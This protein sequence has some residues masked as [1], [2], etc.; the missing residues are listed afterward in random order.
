MLNAPTGDRMSPTQ[1]YDAAINEYLGPDR[2]SLN[3]LAHKY[4]IPETS[5]RRGIK[6]LGI[7]RGG[8]TERK[9]RL[10]ENHFSG[11]LANLDS[12]GRSPTDTENPELLQARIELEAARDIEDMDGALT[13]CRR[14]LWRLKEIVDTLDCP[15]DIKAACEATARAV[16]VIRRIRGLDAPVDFSDWSDDELTYLAQTGRPPSGRR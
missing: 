10:V 8:A 1:D 12:P 2:P 14:A 5:L 11:E 4:G 9:R 13:V 7:V 16:D 3:S 15:R 6:R